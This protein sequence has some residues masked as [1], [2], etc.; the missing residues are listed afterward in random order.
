MTGSLFSFFL[1]NFCTHTVFLSKDVTGH[2][3]FTTLLYQ[4]PPFY[5][6]W[7]QH[8]VSVQRRDR[9]L[10]SPLHC[11]TKVLF[12]SDCFL[13][14][15]F[16]SLS[17]HSVSVQRRDRSLS[18]YSTALQGPSSNLNFLVC[19]LSSPL[20][21]FWTTLYFT[22]CVCPKTWQVAVLSTA[23]SDYTVYLSKDVTGALLPL[24]TPF[25]FCISRHLVPHLF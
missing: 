12:W 14:S 7:R 24:P 4:V 8:S 3:T 25:L 23:A 17:S 5:L 6:I 9:S 10:F 15:L 20:F 11:F 2:C 21:L 22:Q 16:T 19:F 18:F 1:L 13:L